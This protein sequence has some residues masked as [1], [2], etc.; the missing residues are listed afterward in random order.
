VS[1]STLTGIHSMSEDDYQ[2]DKVADQPSLSASI[3]KLL[4]AATPLHAWTAHP[5]LNPNY[6]REEKDIFDRGTIAHALLLQGLRTAHII[7]AKNKDGEVVS[8]WRTKAA[9]EE[10]DEARAAGKIPILECQWH[11]VEA[12]VERARQQLDA[13]KEAKNAFTNGK[14]EQTLT[15]TDESTDGQKVLCRARLDWLHDSFLLIDDYKSTGRDVNPETI[16]SRIVDDWEIQEAFYR[17]AVLKI[18]G[19]EARFRFIAQENTEP[20]ALTVIGLD[21]AFQWLG[22][23][24]VQHAIDLWAKCLKSNRWPSYPDRVCY[25]TLP[26]WAEESWLRK[27]MEQ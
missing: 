24:K 23:K 11:A 5:K 16:A 15:W 1:T 27:E 10:R 4:I 20:Y 6:V 17:R 19:K 13:H 3:A 18:T 7:R 21:P 2:A 12:M 8:D 22:D 9:K 26:K 14:P 25:P